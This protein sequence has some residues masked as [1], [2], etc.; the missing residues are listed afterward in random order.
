MIPAVGLHVDGAAKLNSDLDKL[1]HALSDLHEFWPQLGQWWAG[2]EQSV[3][4]SRGFGRWAPLRSSTILARRRLG[5][6]DDQPLIR[7]RTLFRTVDAA[8][9]VKTEAQ[10][11]VFGSHGGPG[12]AAGMHVRAGDHGPQRNPLPPLRAGEKREVLAMLREWIDSHAG[13]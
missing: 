12:D 11:A 2:R 6:T 8:S 13:S 5:I 7:T 10:F 9:P 3:F 4:D 1:D